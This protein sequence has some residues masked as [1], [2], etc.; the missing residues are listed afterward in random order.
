MVELAEIQAAYY[1]VAATG[2]LIAAVF[3]ILN[4]RISQRNQEISL[5][6]Q[7]LSQKTQELAL[8]TQQQTLET[9]Q[10]QLLM[11]IYQTFMS[12]QLMD[13]E[14]RLYNIEFK[15]SEDYN[16]LLKDKDDYKAFIFYG[17]FLEGLGVLVKN[18]LMDIRLLAE[19]TSA[20]ILWFWEKYRDGVIDCR[21][22]LNW[23]RFFVEVEY[24]YDRCIEYG[25][26][27]PELGIAS[28]QF[29]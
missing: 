13:A 15:K 18:N 17:S 5:K 9:R 4:L 20:A 27:H 3:Y 12:P 24:L 22:K 1:M 2:V 23:P 16:K 14:Y 21:I 7:E 6:N 26:A 10:A 29:A 19:L 28:P 8:K 25:K 11:Q